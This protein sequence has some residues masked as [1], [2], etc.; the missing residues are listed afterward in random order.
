MRKSRSNKKRFLFKIIIIILIISGAIFYLDYISK[1]PIRPKPKLPVFVIKSKIAIIIDD[2]GYNKEKFEEFL[3]LNIKLTF[4]FL[5]AGTYTKILAS[6]AYAKDYGIMLHLPM[7]PISFPKDNPGDDAIFVK[8]N[9][10]DIKKRVN[11]QIKNVPFIVGVNNHMGSKVTQDKDIMFVVLNEIKTK[12]LFFVDSL[13]TEKSICEVVAN[14]IGLPI[15]KRDI[16]L[17]SDQ[18]PEFTRNALHRLVRLAKEKKKVVA[19]GHPLK[20]TIEALREEVPLMLKEGVEFVTISE[21]M[22]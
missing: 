4:S 2:M 1:K 9:K 7:E 20:S 16:F 14:E 13:T 8:M 10:E 21:L 17:D 18:T 3:K 6:L 22:Q 12:N 11:E 15:I 19:I 5:P